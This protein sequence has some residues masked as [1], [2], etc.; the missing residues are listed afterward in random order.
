M[1][2]TD[3][4]LMAA[5][6][7][8]LAEVFDKKPVSPKA[9]EV[10]FDALR[11]FPVER[12]M[13]RLNT[14]ARS[15]GKFP[16]PAEVWKAVNE[17]QVD[18]REEKAAD[19]ARQ[20]RAPIPQ[21]MGRTEFGSRASKAILAILAGSVGCATWDRTRWIEHW[22]GVLATPNEYLIREEMAG[23]AL[24]RWNAPA[25]MLEREPGSDDE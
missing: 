16:T 6:L 14:W 15:H 13:D 12:V 18:R 20:N 8:A 21:W 5:Q 9:L 23:D 17:F 10:W 19:E 3:L 1:H 2:K 4:T 11:E 7:N 24:L 25:A 22:Q